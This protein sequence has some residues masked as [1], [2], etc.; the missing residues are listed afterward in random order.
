MKNI[1]PLV[2]KEM[3]I[4]AIVT[5]SPSYLIGKDSKGIVILV[6]VG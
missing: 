6:D 2:I 3:Q 1:H 4:K 5:F